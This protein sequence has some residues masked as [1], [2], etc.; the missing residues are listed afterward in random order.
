MIVCH[1]PVKTIMTKSKLPDSDYA[2]NP[3][4]GCPHKCVYCYACFMK[5]FT[6]HPEPWGEFLDVKESP[7]ISDPHKYDGK[8]L[9]FGSVTDCYNPYEA[10]YQKTR[11]VLTQ[12][13]GAHAHITIATKSNLVV[14]DLDILKQIP[15]ITVAFSINTLDEKFRNDMDSACSIADRIYAMKTLYE[16]KINTVTFVSPIFPGITQVEEIVQATKAHCNTYWLE[17]LNLRGSYKQIIMDYIKRDYPHLLPLYDAIYNRKDK[18][19]WVELSQHLE[20][21]AKVEG[22]NMVNYFY[23]ELIR[24]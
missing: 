23:H 10:Q 3:Y 20:N 6:G 24:K 11:E 2:V 9:F 16:S 19:Y 17:N 15:H 13:I 5:R 7:P 22:V 12:F 21:H 18:Q 14:R 8:K 4:I 1:K